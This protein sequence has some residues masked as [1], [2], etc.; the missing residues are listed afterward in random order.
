MDPM[1]HKTNILIVG[2]TIYNFEYKRDKEAAII[3]LREFQV[4]GENFAIAKGLARWVEMRLPRISTS[5]SELVFM[6]L[7]LF[8]IVAQASMMHNAREDYREFKSTERLNGLGGRYTYYQ[9]IKRE[10]G[11]LEDARFNFRFPR[12]KRPTTSERKDVV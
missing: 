3:A 10:G 2:G 11:T 4:S 8:E 9:L 7:K 12:H 5:D 1:R 6:H